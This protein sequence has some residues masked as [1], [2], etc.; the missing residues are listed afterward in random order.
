[1]NNEQQKELFEEF[2]KEKSAIEKITDKITQKRRK[3]Y[4]NIAMENVVFTFII[5][6]MCVVTAF[7]LGVER[8]KRLASEPQVIKKEI[9]PERQKSPEAR[10]PQEVTGQ[11]ELKPIEVG[12]PDKISPKSLPYTIQLISYKQK[13][14]ADTEINKLL[15]KNVDAHIIA[16]GRWYQVCAGHFRSVKEAERALRELEDQYQG[17]FVRKK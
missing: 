17:C 14:I 8:G 4:A 5:A 2:K 7:A 11:I 15:K 10:I 9:A 3:L 1:M 13:D 16:S 12:K 6:I